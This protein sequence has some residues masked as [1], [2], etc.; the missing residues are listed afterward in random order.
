VIE[1]LAKAGIGRVSA[2]ADHPRRERQPAREAARARGRRRRTE[3]GWPLRLPGVVKQVFEERSAS[4]PLAG[5]KILHRIRDTRGGDKLYD[6]RF[7]TRGRGQGPYADMIATMFE[8]T[9]ARLGLNARESDGDDEPTTFRRP[10]K[11][12]NQLALF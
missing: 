5:D 10:P 3:A 6:A 11:Q 7:H 4:L 9:V 1:T 8:T 2:C 12:T